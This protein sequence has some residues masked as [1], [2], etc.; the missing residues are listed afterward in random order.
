MTYY[1]RGLDACTACTSS[2]EVHQTVL[3]S[4]IILTVLLLPLFLCVVRT[5]SGKDRRKNSCRKEL[6]QLTIPAWAARVIHYLHG[7][8]LRK[9]RTVVKGMS[10]GNKL[11]M[12]ISHLQ[13]VS[14]LPSTYLL[15]TLHGVHEISN[16]FTSRGWLV[17]FEW[18]FTSCL[19]GGRQ[20]E[21][22][23]VESHL[24]FEFFAP[25][26]ICTLWWMY[27]LVHGVL[28]PPNVGRMGG[29]GE[30]IK[31]A[32]I[33]FGPS[34]ADFSDEQDRASRFAEVVHQA[35]QQRNS[36][37][38]SVSLLQQTDSWWQRM[39]HDGI[40][41][42]FLPYN[43]GSTAMMQPIIT[44]L[45]LVTPYI[46]R[47]A[48]NLLFSMQLSVEGRDGA[49]ATYLE[50]LP[51]LVV[52]SDAHRSIRR[53][54][55]ACAFTYAFV[56]PI[57]FLVVLNANDHNIRHGNNSA[58]ARALSLLTSG[59]RV[60][61]REPDSLAVRA[62]WWERLTHYA[63]NLWR[64]VIARVRLSWE[65]IELLKTLMLTSFMCVFARG[66]SLQALAGLAYV[67]AHLALYVVIKPYRSS[68]NTWYQ[69]LCLL[70]QAW[71]L[72]L[73]LLL[74]VQSSPILDSATVND[75]VLRIL[76]SS[77]GHKWLS[78]ALDI[79]LMI[80]IVFL[81]VCALYG[82]IF[83]EKPL[84]TLCWC[85]DGR[86]VKSGDIPP[87][88]KGEEWHVFLSH[89]WSEAQDQTHALHD[90]LRDM[91]PRGLKCFLDIK[92][93]ITTDDLEDYVRRSKVFVMFLTPN[94]LTA[95]NCAR[96]F[97]TAVAEGKEIVCVIDIDRD[98]T[99]KLTLKSLLSEKEVDEWL[100]GLDRLQL[101]AT[102]ADRKDR[103]AT[104][105]QAKRA[106]EEIL[107]GEENP[108][109]GPIPYTT[110]SRS[111]HELKQT[112]LRLIG[113]QVFV[114]LRRSAQRTGLFPEPQ[115]KLY[116]PHELDDGSFE[117]PEPL[118]SQGRVVKAHV[119]IHQHNDE[120]VN[121]LKLLGAEHACTR[122]GH[123][124]RSASAPRLRVVD[125]E[126]KE[127]ERQQKSRMRQTTM[128]R[129]P[130]RVGFNEL[131]YTRE[132]DVDFAQANRFFV[133]L[134]KGW[135]EA[136]GDSQ[137]TAFREFVE[138]AEGFLDYMQCMPQKQLVCFYEADAATAI[139]DTLAEP[140]GCTFSEL[141]QLWN[142]HDK[143]A[144]FSRQFASMVSRQHARVGDKLKKVNFL[145]L[146]SDPR[147]PHHRVTVKLL[148]KAMCTESPQ[149]S[150]SRKEQLRAEA[151]WR[152]TLAANLSV[153]SRRSRYTDR[154]S[155]MVPSEVVEVELGEPGQPPRAITGSI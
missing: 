20:S 77:E 106:L 143:W 54:A 60:D 126:E 130:Q 82:A 12:S 83:D 151:T 30:R 40:P 7:H 85:D 57:M 39:Q 146:Y 55:M 81:V 18:A 116:M 148:A 84:R 19:G 132:H 66:T 9:V 65:V 94:Y 43:A 105:E 112:T 36:Q 79:S 141:L 109:N 48:F 4:L 14:M 71:A 95:K 135:L 73:C 136:A 1:S 51:Q 140:T 72:F 31:F 15:N 128:A 127:A 98:E 124:H 86:E 29:R 38:P 145:P 87:I 121:A 147:H 50:A 153:R 6:Q 49:I 24:M 62:R 108:E 10:L 76:A 17:D 47:R 120:A 28:N 37:Q 133:F 80:V 144:H 125:L 74:Q 96:E 103:R 78:S 26:V 123:E 33:R 69:A 131:I 155:N 52:A 11:R 5:S 91:L 114:A 42:Y 102:S 99:A 119:Y 107:K 53:V 111:R 58:N 45:W 110:T 129:S 90:S 104:R 22:W 75:S 44:L 34:R 16:V 115:A 88:F 46:A 113:Q 2:D 25:L 154:S 117:D 68:S 23:R 138:E 64:M 35:Q 13:L 92:S 150:M 63:Q 3:L 41:L 122:R 101:L 59:Y 70:A 139:V 32:R 89:K 8:V 149:N 61:L 100:D 67:L 137:V 142:K 118:E 152:R 134:T 21:S 97:L 93:L 56:I 27:G